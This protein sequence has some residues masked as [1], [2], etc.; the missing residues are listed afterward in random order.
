MDVRFEVANSLIICGPS[1]SGKTTWVLKLIENSNVL[2]KNA[3]S[4]IY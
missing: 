1:K 4:K 2:F 3:A